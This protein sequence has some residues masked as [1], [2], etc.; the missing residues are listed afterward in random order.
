MNAGNLARLAAC[1]E[2]SYMEAQTASECV[3]APAP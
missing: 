2:R 1:F 3:A